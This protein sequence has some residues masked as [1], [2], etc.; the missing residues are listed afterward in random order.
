MTKIFCELNTVNELALYNIIGLK[1]ALKIDGRTNEIK[2]RVLNSVSFDF[3]RKKNRPA[4]EILK[5]E[6]KET[7]NI[8]NF[9]Y[10]LGFFSG[11]NS[12]TF[13]VTFKEYKSGLK[14]AKFSLLLNQF[15][16]NLDK[17]IQLI[18]EVLINNYPLSF[19]ENFF[20]ENLTEVDF[21]IHFLVVLRTRGKFATT[22]KFFVIPKGCFFSHLKELLWPALFSDPLFLYSILTYYKGFK[23]YVGLIFILILFYLYK[24]IHLNCR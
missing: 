23:R 22:T 13:R 19:Y 1:N 16:L 21:K 11:C 12:F 2:N 24:L 3:N 15:N 8:Y 4:L 6:D 10:P 18:Q 9:S 14:A 17:F 20:Q 5:K 7:F